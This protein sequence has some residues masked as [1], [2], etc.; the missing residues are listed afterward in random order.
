MAEHFAC[1]IERATTFLRGVLTETEQMQ[2][3]K[4]FQV[5]RHTNKYQGT[6]KNAGGETKYLIQSLAFNGTTNKS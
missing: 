2:K 5:Y 4:L 3:C 1:K 6:S